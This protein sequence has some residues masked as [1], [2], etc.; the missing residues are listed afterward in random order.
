MWLRKIRASGLALVA[1]VPIAEGVGF[2]QSAECGSMDVLSYVITIEIA[3]EV[4]TV[5]ARAEMRLTIE[6][7]T[8]DRL[9]F[10]L[11]GMTVDSAAVDAE[12][13]SFSQRPD[14]LTVNLSRPR[15]VGDTLKV[16][17]YYHG[18]PADGLIFRRNRYGRPTVFADN[19]PSRAR[20]WFP[21]VDH[22]SDKA[23]VEFR[24]VAP[25][26]WSIVANGRSIETSRWGEGRTLTVWRTERPIPVYTMVVGAAE[27]V[28]REIGKYCAEGRDS[29]V[30]ITQWTFAEDEER[31]ARLFRRAP[32]AVAFFD[33][34]VGPF[35]YDK[36][37]LVQS[38][39][40]YGGMENASAIFFTERLSEGQRGDGLVAHEIAHQWFGD[41]VTEREWPHLWLSEGFATYFASVFFEFVDGDSAGHRIRA[42]NEARFMA[43]VE[44]V[45]RP[46]IEDEPRDLF[47]LLNAN[48][49]QKGAWVLHML[50]QLVGD[51]AFFEGIREYY[52]EFV[53]ATALS[54]DLQRIMEKTSGK[55][56]GWFFDQWLLRP[57]YPKVK[58]HA[59][60]DE[61]AQS[62]ELSVVQSQTWPAFRFPLRIDVEGDGFS[63]T[64]TFWIDGRERRF[65]WSMPGKPDGVIIDP[66]NALLG[67]TE[68]EK[69][70]EGE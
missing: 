35:P 47:R 15:A 23:A 66:E 1:F 56:L 59:S 50:R 25:A 51:E 43:S 61:A 8:A 64:R 32:E 53:H 29:C 10:D 28:V 7:S 37:A 24:V 30:S 19:W 70:T 14:G 21:G 62:L 31:A 22:P 45:A 67:P 9:H 42:D 54:S 36:L 49:Y 69:A 20:F 26:E 46:I 4:D 3:A 40:R 6:D 33:S 16:A 38:T 57:G 39:T 60:W 17:I 58:V 13:A 18:I 27:M 65:D 48:N 5:V 2:P 12:S 34:L 68:I 41:A 63:V 52:R 11:V 44:D 55:D